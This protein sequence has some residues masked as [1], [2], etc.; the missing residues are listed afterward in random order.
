MRWIRNG[1]RLLQSIRRR[2]WLS[3][4]VEHSC[5][6]TYNEIDIPVFVGYVNFISAGVQKDYKSAWAY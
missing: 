3:V 4:L 2:C 5:C 6:L 1:R